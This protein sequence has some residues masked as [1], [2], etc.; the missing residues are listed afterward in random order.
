MLDFPRL[1]DEL[2]RRLHIG[3]TQWT[4][5]PRRFTDRSLHEIAA[6]S[7]TISC[8][9]P[10]HLAELV[11]QLSAFETYSDE[12]VS[13]S[14][15]DAALHRY[16]GDIANRAREIIETALERVTHTEGLNINDETSNKA[17]ETEA[18]TENHG[19]TRA[20]TFRRCTRRDPIA[21]ICK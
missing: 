1:V 18:Y 15:T 12:C 20:R 14:P 6:L 16:L 7:P 8:E 11:M 5:A 4:R 3:Q 2:F 9:C 19:P 21:D 17:A 10:R 13:T